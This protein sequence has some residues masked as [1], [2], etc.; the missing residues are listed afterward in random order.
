MSNITVIRAFLRKTSWVFAPVLL[1]WLAADA[2]VRHA[3]AA[4]FDALFHAELAG[5]VRS[6]ARQNHGFS[7]AVELD[8][9]PRYRFF[10]AKQQGGAAGF[11]ATAAIGDSLQKQP[12]SDTLVLIKQG[13]KVRYAFKKV[14]D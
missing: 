3:N 8:N 2:Y 12:E 10:P 1:L 13:G 9:H 7:V 4:A 5:K 6:L 14:L 11:L